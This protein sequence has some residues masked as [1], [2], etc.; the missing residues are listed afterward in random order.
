MILF[1]HSVARCF[2]DYDKQTLGFYNMGNRSSFF[3]NPVR[4][5]SL[6]SNTEK[7]LTFAG[8]ENKSNMVENVN[9]GTGTELL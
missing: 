4:S 7:V 6:C 9:G 3:S 8:K 5:N 1:E 2:I